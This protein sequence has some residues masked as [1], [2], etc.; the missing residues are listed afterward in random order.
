MKAIAVLNVGQSIVLHVGYPRPSGYAL[1][2]KK[3]A[4]NSKLA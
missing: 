2:Q 1:H 4:V 3:H